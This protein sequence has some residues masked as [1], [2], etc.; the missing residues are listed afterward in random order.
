MGRKARFTKDQF[1]GAAL[2][3][4]AQNGPRG[5]T[6]QALAARVGAPIGSVYHRFP[7]REV[8]L[9]RLWLRSVESFQAG[10]I[11]ALENNDG[12]AAALHVPR[13]VRNHY[14]ESKVL[15]LYRRDELVSGNWPP[16]IG[17]RAADLV[18]ELNQAF[19]AFVGRQCGRFRPEYAERLKFAL[20][21]APYG[22]VRRYLE[23]DEAVPERVDGFIE[24]TYRAITG[25]ES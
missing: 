1:L 2:A 14:E 4:M 3:L 9:A 7:S 8:L 17:R 20:I 24:E 23:K 19:K 25:D 6:I 16:A 21:D 18:D 15:L 5:V 13:W 22:A 12:L 10:F 11:R